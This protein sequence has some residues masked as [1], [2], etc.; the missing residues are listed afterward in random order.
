MKNNFMSNY[1]I[2]TFKTLYLALIPIFT[3]PYINRIIL[4]ELLGKV[5]WLNV[6]TDY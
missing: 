3:F 6:F 2:T 5:I 4:P 1:L